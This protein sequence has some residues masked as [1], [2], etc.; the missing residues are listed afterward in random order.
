MIEHNIERILI[1][2]EEIATTVAEMGAKITHDFEGKELIAICILKGSIMFFADLVRAIELDVKMEFMTL[3]SYGD[4][5]TSSGYVV[6]QQDI[7]ENIKGK[8]VLVVEDIIDSGR[9]MKRLIEILSEREPAMLR[10]ATLL[11]KPSA[12]EVEMN[13]DYTGVSIA[14][15]FVVGYGLDFAQSYRNLSDICVLASPVKL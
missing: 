4:G 7:T 11:D 12:R 14:N 2:R 10:V 9:T 15:E 8:N 3:S 5:T 6:V 13:A 1:S